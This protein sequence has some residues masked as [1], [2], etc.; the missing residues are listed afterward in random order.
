MASTTIRVD[1]KTHAQLLEMSAARGSTLMDTVRDAAEALR[2]QQFA[3]RVVAEMTALRED[4]DAWAAYL[5]EAEGTD[6]RDGV[7]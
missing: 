7:T 2:R 1:A 4:P 6:V 5:A 3:T